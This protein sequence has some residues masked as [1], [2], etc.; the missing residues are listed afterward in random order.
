MCKKSVSFSQVLV[1]VL[2]ICLQLVTCI[3]DA[4]CIVDNDCGIVRL[5]L[6]VLN[7]PCDWYTWQNIL[8]QRICALTDAGS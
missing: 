8:S 5:W 6:S 7:I 1:Y 2:F 4:V 3:V